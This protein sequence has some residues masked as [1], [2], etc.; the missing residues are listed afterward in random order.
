M[1]LFL[2]ITPYLDERFSLDQLI[3]LPVAQRHVLIAEFNQRP[4][5]VTSNIRLLVLCETKQEEQP[6]SLSIGDN[7]TKSAALPAMCP[8]DPLLQQE[9]AKLG[10]GQSALDLTNGSTQ[11]AL[12][13][14]F[15]LGPA[16]E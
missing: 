4:S 13:E 2:A 7:H 5:L 16:R 9:S 11:I 15:S 1:R 3:Q 12:R 10:L 8:R 6:A 14:S